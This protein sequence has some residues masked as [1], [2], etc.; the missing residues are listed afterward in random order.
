MCLNMLLTDGAICIMQKLVEGGG[1][2]DPFKINH[3]TFLGKC[4]SMSY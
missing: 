4:M 1:V 2:C 3:T